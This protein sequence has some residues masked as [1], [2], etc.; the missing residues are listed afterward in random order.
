MIGAHEFEEVKGVGVMME[1]KQ[2]E[3]TGLS[4]MRMTG[5]YQLAD[6][7]A[8][9]K[10]E[11]EQVVMISTHQMRFHGREQT[12]RPIHRGIENLE[13]WLANAVNAASECEGKMVA[14]TTT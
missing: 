11:T 1:E 7:R 14:G 5:D 3:E 4:V 13:Y 9:G 12:L 10:S 2:R 6:R 8:W